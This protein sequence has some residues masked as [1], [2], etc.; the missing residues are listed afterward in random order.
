AAELYQ[1][2]CIAST[3]GTDLIYPRSSGTT[4]SPM[5][6]APLPAPENPENGDAHKGNG[7]DDGW[8]VLEGLRRRLDD[9]ALQGRATQQQVTQ[10]TESIAAL[11]EI[12]RRRTRGINLNSFIAY[13][14]FTALCFTAFYLLYQSR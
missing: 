7:A 9:Q 2:D 8:V 14:I 11:V 3:R 5:S 13:L 4:A 10:L 1:L 6:A 12:Q